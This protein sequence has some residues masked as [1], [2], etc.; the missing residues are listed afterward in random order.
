VNTALKDNLEKVKEQRIN[1]IA[2]DYSKFEGD[3]ER[4]YATIMR[5]L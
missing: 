1:K 5:Q 4:F 2:D 3:W